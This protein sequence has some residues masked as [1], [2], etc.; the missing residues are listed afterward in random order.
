MVLLFN[1][2]LCLFSVED[3]SIAHTPIINASLLNKEDFEC[4]LCYRLLHLPVTTPCG[5]IFSRPCL[6]KVLDHKTECPLCKS[7]LAEVR[8]VVCFRKYRFVQIASFVKC[9]K[10]KVKDKF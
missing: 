8:R 5:H 6:D 9:D 10:L 4:S 1:V 3:K 2:V 7:C